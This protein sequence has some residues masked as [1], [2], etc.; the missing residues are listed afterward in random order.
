[1]RLK[2][3]S[4]LAAALPVVVS[5]FSSLGVNSCTC[6]PDSWKAAL[7][8]TAVIQRDAPM[9]QHAE[10]NLAELCRITLS[11]VQLLAHLRV[12]VDEC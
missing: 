6:R 12:E 2:I 3:H 8:A 11:F 9:P 10:L 7:A 4:S 5:A 1:M